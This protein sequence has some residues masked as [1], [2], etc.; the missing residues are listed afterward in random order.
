MH[1]DFEEKEEKEERQREEDFDEK[2]CCGLV[3]VGLVVLD[4][5]K[6]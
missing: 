2:F 6:V 4:A 1:R 3:G 5:G